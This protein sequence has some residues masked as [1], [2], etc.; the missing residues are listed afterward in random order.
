MVF[1]DYEVFLLLLSLNLVYKLFTLLISFL[2]TIPYS[3]RSDS[4][5]EMDT[6]EYF[7][8]RREAM[9]KEGSQII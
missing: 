6:S 8:R 1:I 9:K 7:A 4:E 3:C 2:L 5:M